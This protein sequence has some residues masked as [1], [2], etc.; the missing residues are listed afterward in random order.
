M[1][2]KTCPNR[3]PTALSSLTASGTTSRPIP[4][5]ASTARVAF[6]PHSP[7]SPAGCPKCPLTRLFTLD[8]REAYLVARRSRHRVLRLSR[9]TPRPKRGN[10][11]LRFTLHERPLTLEASA[12]REHGGR[13]G[14]L[15]S[16]T[17]SSCG[18]HA[19]STR[20]KNSI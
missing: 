11:T 16:S 4:S 5:P 1:N 12:A 7:Y 10:P 20:H 18:F 3:S 2:S 19:G 17:S 14:R 13:V 8:S 6:T 15:Y 9:Q